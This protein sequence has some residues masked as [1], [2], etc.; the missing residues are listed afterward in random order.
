MRAAFVLSALLVC[1]PLAG[2][3]EPSPQ[4]VASVQSR[5]DMVGYPQVDAASLTTR[6]LA[7]LHMQIGS[8]YAVTGSRW[9]EGRRKVQ[10]ILR[11]D[12]YETRR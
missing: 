3:A 10:A 6:Q 11:W 7:A 12:G 5:L 8:R 1:A 9:L 4:F 2:K